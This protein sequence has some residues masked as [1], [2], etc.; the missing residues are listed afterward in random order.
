MN[1]PHLASTCGRWAVALV[2]VVLASAAAT[3]FLQPLL[4]DVSV[5]DARAFGAGWLTLGGASTARAEA[6]QYQAIPIE[7]R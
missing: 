2:A 4:F 1:S 7:E 5:I 3:R 6:V